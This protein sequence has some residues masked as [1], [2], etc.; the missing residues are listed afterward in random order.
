VD[1]KHSFDSFRISLSEDT[2]VGGSQT[3]T[4]ELESSSGGLGQQ[5]NL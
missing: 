3:P 2:H 1:V 5:P 4:F